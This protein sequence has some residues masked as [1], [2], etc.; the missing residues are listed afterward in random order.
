MSKEI[1]HPPQLP[2]IGNILDLQDE[3]P[4]RALENL[5]NI[6]GPIYKLRI[7]NV[8]RVFVCN[9][10][11][12]DE[13]CD[14]KRFWK[15]TSP[16][17]SSL[18]MGSKARG[19]FTAPS[20]ADP[21]W[22][23]AHRTLLPAFGPLAIQEMFPE[24]YDIASQ[25]VMKWAR[26]GSE[27]RIPLT[28][29]FTRL[30]LDTIALCAMDYRFNSFY[31][32]EMHPFVEAMNNTLQAR[33]DANKLPNLIHNLILGPKDDLKADSQFMDQ[34]AGELVQHRRDHPTEKKDLLN[35]MINGKDP[36]TG[37]K[38]RDNLIISNMITFL[39]ASHE[40]TSGLLS[41][42]FL[43][44]LKNPE[45]YYKAQKE[46]DEVVGKKKIKVGHLQKLKYLNAV[47]RETLRLHPTAPAFSRGIRPDHEGDAVTL[48]N[49]EYKVNRDTQIV[50]VITKSHR[51]PKVYGENAI[52]FQPERM[53]DENFEKLPNNAWKPFGTGVRACI[54]RAFAWQEALLVIAL[55]LQNF[56][57]RLDDAKYELRIKQAL[58]IKPKDL[59][60]RATL[61]DELT[62]TSLMSEM[63][64][65][66]QQD[67]TLSRT[68]TA[69][70]AAKATQ[71]MTIL[72]GSNSG[73]CQ[74]LAQ[75]VVS[76]AARRGFRATTQEL[77]SAVHEVPQG[78]PVVIICA[79]YDGQPTDNARQ[80]I[81]WL[82]SLGDDRKAF[83]GVTYAVFGCGHCTY[84]GNFCYVF[85]N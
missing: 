5:A 34:V 6:Y 40:T 59:Y 81:A 48:G 74:S 71:T 61:R 11:L 58:T 80:F 76:A 10:A 67:L 64:R 73:T 7:Q 62:A 1:P 12:V 43:E 55:L 77:D 69:E 70:L 4:A 75:K 42:A 47:L 38:M 14:E 20:E 32:D 68:N 39:I 16:A 65:E 15:M 30:T 49:G 18:A 22:V 46:V 50:C 2:F 78:E 29:D 33:S 13:V 41:F 85:C 53:L 26:K 57:L 37:E 27:Y 52:E 9:H 25:L 54:G 3:V 8:E 44:L 28:D 51:D 72:Y 35:A 79:S 82:E 84:F 21:D 66:T 45:T 31:Q 17:L 24:M 23:Q 63:A 56:N 19:L 36:K 60:V 83:G